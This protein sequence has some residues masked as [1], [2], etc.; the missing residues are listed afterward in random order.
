MA[1]A[2]TFSADFFFSEALAIASSSLEVEPSCWVSTF[3]SSSS[4]SLE[5]SDSLELS[6]FL[7]CL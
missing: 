3:S 7:W 2:S 5:L 4:E 1:S 6:S